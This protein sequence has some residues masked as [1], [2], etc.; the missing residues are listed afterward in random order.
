M[1]SASE[2]PALTRLFSSAVVHEMARKGRS[3]LVRRLLDHSGVWRRC[4][5][6]A[7]VGDAFDAAFSI[8]LR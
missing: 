4:T 6:S 8:H 2:L 1:S 5:A 7:T 3:P